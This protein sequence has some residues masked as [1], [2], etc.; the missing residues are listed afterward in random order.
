M[1]YDVFADFYDNLTQNVDY[2]AKANYL[3]KL[4]ERF[5]HDTGCTLDMACGTG[6]LTIELKKRGLDI[7][8]ADMSS[9][10]LTQAQ[11]KAFDEGLEILFLKQKMQSLTLYGTIDTCICTLDSISH[12]EGQVNVQKTFDKVSY[13]ME[14]GGLFVFDV[15]TIYKHEKILGNNT[16]VYDTDKV[17][18][19]WQNTYIEQQHR[20][21]IELDFFIPENNFYRR[22]SEIFSEYAYTRE[23]IQNMLEKSGFKVL[24]V[25]NDMTF[26]EPG[27]DTQRMTFA[28]M[29]ES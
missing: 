9:E 20:V 27:E 23:N 6:T 2:R 10:M 16:F 29:K 18:C 3:C 1:S 24:A 4:F 8:G 12:L 7:F 15:N 26:E 21:K 5:N 22:E 28:A 11:M 17:Y 25:Y 19:V 13:Y 14:K